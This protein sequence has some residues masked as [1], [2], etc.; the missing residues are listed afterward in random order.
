MD[1]SGGIDRA[2]PLMD[3]GDAIPLGFARLMRAGQA[4]ASGKLL[5]SNPGLTYSGVFGELIRLPEH[6]LHVDEPKP[7]IHLFGADVFEM[8]ATLDAWYKT[9]KVCVAGK[10]GPY[11]RTVRPDVQRL[12][13]G[14]VAYPVPRQMMTES[15]FELAGLYFDSARVFFGSSAVYGEHLWAGFR[16]E[17][18]NYLHDHLFGFHPDPEVELHSMYAAKLEC[19]RRGESG[20]EANKAYKRAGQAFQLAFFEAVCRPFGFGYKDHTKASRR[21]PNVAK[22]MIMKLE[23]MVH[24]A[25]LALR[26][27]CIENAELR[28]RVE[29][30]TAK[31]EEDARRRADAE[32]RSNKHYQT[33]ER[34]AGMVD[35]AEKATAAAQARADE[36]RRARLAAEEGWRA[37]IDS[38]RLVEQRIVLAKASVDRLKEDVASYVVAL[39]EREASEERLAHRVRVLEAEAVEKDN[40]IRSLSGSGGGGGGGGFPSPPPPSSRGSGGGG[41]RRA[42]PSPSSSGDAGGDQLE[43]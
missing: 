13:A 24:E 38:R 25:G 35:A 12:Q 32:G 42:R 37:E 36:E 28:E 1:G 27:V 22:R 5:K 14:I 2:G 26:P 8:T 15:D 9:T 23:K 11:E 17:D 10:T 21:L 6:S 20:S 29:A 43:R 7:P 31:A 19:K 30:L 41:A 39:A 3:F 34:L 4:R 16:H 33:N 18:E 40:L